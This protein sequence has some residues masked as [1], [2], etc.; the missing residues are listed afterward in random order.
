MGQLT[1]EIPFPGGELLEFRR[2]PVEGLALPPTVSSEN[3]NQ[4]FFDCIE[5]YKKSYF[6][7]WCLATNKANWR[8]ICSKPHHVI[9]IHGFMSSLKYRDLN[10]YDSAI[11][12]QNQTYLYWMVYGELFNEDDLSP[13]DKIKLDT[14]YEQLKDKADFT[15]TVGMLIN[16]YTF[17]SFLARKNLGGIR[18]VVTTPEL[19]IH[20][21]RDHEVRKLYD[22][23]AEHQTENYWH[24]YMKIFRSYAFLTSHILIHHNTQFNECKKLPMFHF[25]ND[26]IKLLKFRYLRHSAPEPFKVWLNQ[27][28]NVELLDTSSGCTIL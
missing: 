22:A 6:L 2:Y 13:E 28:Y 21:H 17:I 26:T 12:L 8:E 16:R 1:L 25:N 11:D 5:H 7:E 20:A 19:L 15:S 27:N 24:A 3:P 9:K 4:S 23:K 14:V 18:K 10:L